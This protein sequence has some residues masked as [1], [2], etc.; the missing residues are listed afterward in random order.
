[1]NRV[2][3]R[4]L[5]AAWGLGYG[6]ALHALHGAGVPVVLGC[7]AIAAATAGG[8]WSPDVDQ[9]WR[10]RTVRY[11]IWGRVVERK[12]RPS[13]LL[14]LARWAWTRAAW[15]AA[16]LPWWREDGLRRVVCGEDPTR[17]RGVTHWPEA[18]AAAALALAVVETPALV[19]QWLL[20]WPVLPW[21]AAWAGLVGWCSHL[22]GDF[23]HGRQVW[24]QDGPGIPLRPWWG[25]VGVGWRSG[26][27]GAHLVAWGLAVPASVF[28][29]KVAAGV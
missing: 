26:G 22:A 12:V 14:R 1:M 16:G 8:R 18:A 29:V 6:E 23:V 3:H 4:L 24:G 25:H 19:G 13:W 9:Y 5:G 21:W 20:G 28:L 15:Y 10:D 11:R 27:A 2:D 17:H 7:G